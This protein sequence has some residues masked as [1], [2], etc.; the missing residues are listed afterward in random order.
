MNSCKNS[1]KKKI[2]TEKNS[3]DFS[4]FKS[5]FF[6]ILIKPF[7]FTRMSKLT[8]DQTHNSKDIHHPK[9]KNYNKK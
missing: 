4:F 6:G 3:H 7:Q 1:G 5:K 2:F 9:L 8:A